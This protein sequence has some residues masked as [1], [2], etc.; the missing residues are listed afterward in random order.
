MVDPDVAADTGIIMCLSRRR[1]FRKA[2]RTWQSTVRETL[3]TL[4]WQEKRDA[5][6]EKANRYRLPF[7]YGIRLFFACGGFLAPTALERLSVKYDDRADQKNSDQPNGNQQWGSEG[8][9]DALP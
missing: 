1:G 9:R 4:G 7:S 3:H 6:M 2:A 8:G 5:K